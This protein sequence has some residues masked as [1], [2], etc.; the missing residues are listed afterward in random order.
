MLNI[1]LYRYMFV[2]RFQFTIYIYAYILK[3][4]EQNHGPHVFLGSGLPSHCKRAATKSR[5]A[6]DERDEKMA[7]G[8]GFIRDHYQVWGGSNLMQMYG[9]F[10]VLTTSAGFGLVL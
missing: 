9:N 7:R 4:D 10:R 3:F 2:S 1:F 8:A 5:S 6:R